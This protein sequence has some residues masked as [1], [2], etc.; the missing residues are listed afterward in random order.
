M[1][2]AAEF[3]RR[4]DAVDA[5][6]AAGGTEA[7]DAYGVA[8]ELSSVLQPT[9]QYV[10]YNVAHA[11]AFIASPDRKAYVRWLGMFAT[12]AD[13]Q[14]HANRVMRRD[15]GLDTRM[16]PVAEFF[17]ITR[18]R[19][20]DV[21]EDQFVLD[22]AGAP[23]LDAATGLPQTRRV[24][25]F[26]DT[27][28]RY[29]EVDK[30][31]SQ[32]ERHAAMRR[33]QRRETKMNA[34]KRRMGETD[35]SL[36]QK[37]TEDVGEEEAT[38]AAVDAAA[39]LR[40]ADDE[41]AALLRANLVAPGVAALEE[42]EVGS[43]Q[44][45][46]HLRTV[47]PAPAAV[48]TPAAAAPMAAPMAAVAPAVAAGADAAA[49]EPAVVAAP[50]AAPMAAE[51]RAARRLASEARAVVEGTAELPSGNSGG[52]GGGG[53]GTAAV[54]GIPLALRV[55]GQELLAMAVVNDYATLDEHAKIVDAWCARR[56]AAYTAARDALLWRTLETHGKLR[57]DA[58]SGRPLTYAAADA[59]RKTAP[60]SEASAAAQRAASDAA[61][62]AA[63]ARGASA[64][65]AARLGE[66]AAADVD[67]SGT[68]AAT[69]AEVAA[70]GLTLA[71][72]LPPMH[73]FVFRWL[74]DNPPPP[75]FNIWGEFI[76]A[77]AAATDV[78][79]FRKHLSDVLAARQ[80]AAPQVPPSQAAAPPGGAA[81]AAAS[82]AGDAGD[83]TVTSGAVAALPPD[84]Q[85]SERDTREVALWVRKRDM[86]VEQM[87]WKWS[88]CD[89]LPL[90]PEVLAAWYRDA[91]NAPPNLDSLPEQ[92]EPAVAAYGAFASDEDARKWEPSI[93]RVRALDDY[94]IGFVRMYVWVRVADADN[95]GID[96]HYR[97]E[98][99]HATMAAQASQ[100]ARA[101]ELKLEART[102]RRK[103]NTVTVGH[104]AVVTAAELP[105][106]L[107]EH[108]WAVATTATAA[109]ESQLAADIAAGKARGVTVAL[110]EATLAEAGYMSKAD[111]DG[112]V[113]S[114]AE[115]RDARRAKRGRRAARV[116]QHGAAGDFDS[117]GDEAAA[118]ALLA[119][120]AAT[121][122]TKAKPPAAGG[123]VPGATAVAGG[124]GGGGG[125]GGAAERGAAKPKARAAL[126][127]G[128]LPTGPLPTTAAGAAGSR[129]VDWDALDISR[130]TPATLGGAAHG[131]AAK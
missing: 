109:A 80:A 42:D 59:A 6:R 96:R 14:L 128:P 38:A 79:W 88:G 82:G 123:T 32:L 36:S 115:A 100:A 93:D 17:G 1:R 127:T 45:L 78:G 22:A 53:G 29:A 76:G 110:G 11:G 112:A 4:M 119:S 52:G 111:F 120:V 44:V 91:A 72:V 19:Y 68:R 130:F 66:A 84:L 24:R 86:R 131:G 107:T 5:Y 33:D 3:T 74:F 92:E 64:Y 48:P 117:S 41:A 77:D 20:R 58:A 108:E 43:A 87:K 70:A 69:V 25:T 104:N 50:M 126:P 113:A 129:G 95:E 47:V 75:G 102:A 26:F 63:R 13:A 62:E 27:A 40:L 94:D 114:A 39:S 37:L 122:V 67:G 73:N 103:V 12:K 18:G 89:H 125:G 30:V 121:A 65:Q 98:H 57:A 90:R 106:G 60:K 23:L 54:K 55:P 101:N 35:L 46:A 2:N 10:L 56:D 83:A 8:A 97:N 118:A 21:W 99:L 31:R 51:G 61:I 81:A 124:D 34:L 105:S 28:T 116:A 85:P 9:Q 7:I 71:D 15:P 49:P 16:M